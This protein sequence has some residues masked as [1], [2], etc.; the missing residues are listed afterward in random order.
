MVQQHSAPQVILQAT[1]FPRRNDPN[2]ALGIALSSLVL[3]PRLRGQWGVSTDNTLA[4][5]DHSGQGRAMTAWG[6]AGTPLAYES[7]ISPY[8]DFI[9]ANTQ[10]YQ[11][12]DVAA[13]D[14]TEELTMWTWVRFHAPSAAA[15]VYFY[16][17]WL[18]AGNQ[19]AYMLHKTAGEILSFSISNTGADVFAVADAAANYAVDTWLFVA[20][21]FTPSLELKLWVGNGETGVLNDYTNLVAIPATIFNSDEPLEVGRGNQT[22]YLDGYEVLWGLAAYALTDADIFNKFHQTRPLYMW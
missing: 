20:G 12:A 7:G 14:I 8:H 22:N 21:R 10:Y 1:D 4:V 2:Y 5:Y 3:T 13:I 18:V 9:R 6:G 15:V 16:S 17:K 11:Y 19:Q